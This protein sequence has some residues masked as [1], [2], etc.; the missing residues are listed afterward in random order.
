MLK[1]L[2]FIGKFSSGLTI[3]G[4]GLYSCTYIVDGGHRGVIW[5]MG[6]GVRKGVYGEGINFFI[7]FYQ[8]PHIFDVRIRPRVI[9]TRTGSK[10]LQNVN[11]SLRVLFRPEESHLPDILKKFRI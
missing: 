5:D 7:P 8:K 4:L 3:L 2:N 11:I 9:T 10:D 1:F 6:K